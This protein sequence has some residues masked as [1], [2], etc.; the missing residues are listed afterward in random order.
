MNINNKYDYNSFDEVAKIQQI[1]ILPCLQAIRDHKK[2]Y[3]GICEDLQI[4]GLKL[5]K[6]SLQQLMRGKH[7][8]FTNLR[9]FVILYRYL[10]IEYNNPLLYA[11]RLTSS[12]DDDKNYVQNK[13]NS[14]DKR[15]KKID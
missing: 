9:Q 5:N 14:G 15:F 10:G 4:L 7:V 12:I 6:N 8:A 3:R 1:L 2:T 11:T 13:I